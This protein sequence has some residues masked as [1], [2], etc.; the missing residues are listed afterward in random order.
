MDLE[1]EKPEALTREA[2][3]HLRDEGLM[4]AGSP[5]S[6]SVMK[7]SLQLEEAYRALAILSFLEDG[8]IDGFL[9]GMSLSAAT[10]LR[11][12]TCVARGMACPPALLRITHTISIFTALASGERRILADL[13]RNELTAHVSAE[14]PPHEVAFAR[15]LRLVVTGHL[16]KAREPFIRFARGRG[17]AS[18][19]RGEARAGAYNQARA[20][21]LAGILKSDEVRFNEGLERFI[22]AL[23]R[24]RGEARLS[25][26]AIGFARLGHATGLNVTAQDPAIPAELLGDAEAPY[27]D[28]AKILPPIEE[29]LIDIPGRAR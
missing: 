3:I 9:H 27:P 29:E 7:G 18:K 19:G 11:F 5:Y 16:A 21:I 10:R 2:W 6:A 26:E 17:L 13:A 20:L 23:P 1:R 28:P 4:R 22:E 25:I 8:D 24:R 15:A 12:L 14:D